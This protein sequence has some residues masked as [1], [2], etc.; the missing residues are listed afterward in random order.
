MKVLMVEPEKEPYEKEIS[1]LADMQDLVGGLIQPIYPFAESACLVCN[2]T[3][4]M[5]NLPMNR[6]L[7]DENG[8]LYDIVCGNFFICG[9]GEEDFVSLPPDL[10]E[11]YKEQ[12]LS[13]EMFKYIG[14]RIQPVKVTK[15]YIQSLN[16]QQE[17]VENPDIEAR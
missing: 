7:Y 11:K 8:R 9:L 14:G 3:G 17:R 4:K 5:M 6:A 10:M 16:N 12:F 2:D 13:P 15:E 1:E